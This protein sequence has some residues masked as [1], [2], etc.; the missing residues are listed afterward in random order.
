MRNF[1]DIL[2]P[3][4]SN[5]WRE[6]AALQRQMD[7]MFNDLSRSEW[8]D[9]NFI[10]AC[11]FEE[12]EDKYSISMD[13]PGMSKDEIQVDISGNTLTVTGE[14]REEKREGKGKQRSQERYH[15]RIERTFTLPQISDTEN[16]Q[17]NYQDG[18]LRISI[19]KSETAKARR[20]E[21]GEGKPQAK[22]VQG[23]SEGQS[24]SSGQNRTQSQSPKAVPVQGKKE[25]KGSDKA[26]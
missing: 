20:I 13:M 18:V 23:Q 6:F 19:P 7:R 17:A 26:A 4:R 11:D 9:E 16:I 3:D 1:L 5:N 15:G 2:R 22:Q 25:Q 8:R 14:H 24:Q 21:I 10:P 12:A